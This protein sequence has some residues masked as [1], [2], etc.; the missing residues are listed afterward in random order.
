MKV[1]MENI[2]VF[3]P[4]E[5]ARFAVENGF[6]GFELAIEYPS[7]TPAHVFAKRRELVDVLSSGNLVRLAHVPTFVDI[8]NFYDELK[9]AS[10]SVTLK[11]MEAAHAI[12][13]EVVVV[14]PGFRFPLAPRETSIRNTI[15]SLERIIDAAEEYGFVLGVE[16]LPSGVLPGAEYFSTVDE[17][18]ELFS[19]LN[20]KRLKFTL[21]IAHASIKPSDPP[22]KFIDAFYGRLV[23]VHVSDNLGSRDDH[24]P[25]GVGRIDYRGPL[26]TLREKGYN[27]T[28]TL[29]VFTPERDYLLVSKRKVE[30]LLSGELGHVARS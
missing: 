13:A 22:A 5:E 21:D 14:H 4:V 10:V 23:H 24:L 7:S 11:A 19:Q 26:R 20:S 9:E 28:V 6:D 2:T 8:S 17:F 27:G 30:G 25:L 1:C 3:D 29:E 18:R 15:Q 12:E 16:N